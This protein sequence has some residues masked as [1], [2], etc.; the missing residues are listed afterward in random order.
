MEVN[1]QFV[2]FIIL[3]AAI[4]GIYLYYD[5]QLAKVKKQLMI[6]SNQLRKN[7]TQYRAL[8]PINKPLNIKFII[9]SSQIGITNTG[10]KLYLAPTL[11]SPKLNTL[12]IKMEVKI[13]DSAIVDSLLWFYVNLP[14]DSDI[15]CR[16]WILK[17]DFSTIFPNS[18]SAIQ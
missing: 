1:L 17:N 5:Q 12:S 13:L 6:T 18:N 14:I 4:A 3:I 16:G 8:T 15:N 10:A 7:K 9:P 11:D 2:I